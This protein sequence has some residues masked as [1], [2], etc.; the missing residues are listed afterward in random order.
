MPQISP[1]RSS[2]YG[3]HAS[4]RWSNAV[5]H[6][7]PSTVNEPVSAGLTLPPL[8]EAASG[9]GTAAPVSS[10]QITYV[11]APAPASPCAAGAVPM[12]PSSAFPVPAAVA[13]TAPSTMR[14]YA[15]S[16]SRMR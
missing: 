13:T 8:M 6:A 1:V 12:E 9:A 11:P 15:P 4:T 7:T 2:V 14:R 5:R 16:S 10:S 3:A